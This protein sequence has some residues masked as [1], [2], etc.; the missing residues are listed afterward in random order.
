MRDLATISSCGDA[1]ANLDD[2]NLYFDIDGEMLNNPRKL[3]RGSRRLGSR[4]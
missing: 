3:G 2:C 1:Y 4:G